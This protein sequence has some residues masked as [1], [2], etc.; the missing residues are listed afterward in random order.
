MSIASMVPWFSVY[1]NLSKISNLGIDNVPVLTII[2]GFLYMYGIFQYKIFNAVPIA[3]DMVFR[4]SR[5]AILLV[6]L[7]DTIIDV[8]DAFLRMYPEFDKSF[9]KNTLNAFIKE[10]TEFKGKFN[11]NAKFQYQ[12]IVNGQILHYSAEIIKILTEEGFEIGKILVIDDIT[13]FIEKQNMLQTIASEAIYK[14]EI[15]EKSKVSL[16]YLQP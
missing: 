4:K 11:E 5:E 6:D 9:K 1:L 10:H 2:T 8:N 7:T 15:I 3:K 16:M 12:L 14:A 13:L